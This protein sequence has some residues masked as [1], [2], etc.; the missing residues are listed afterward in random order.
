MKNYPSLKDAEAAALALASARALE[1]GPGHS[2]EGFSDSGSSVVGFYVSG[3]DDS[4]FEEF[5][6]TFTSGGW[7][8]ARADHFQDPHPQ[9]L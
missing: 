9:V 2:A 7:A 4:G 5:V 1:R 3:P 6:P 8:V